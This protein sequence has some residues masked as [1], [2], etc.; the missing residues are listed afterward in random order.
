MN[1]N[2]IRNGVTFGVIGMESLSHG[3]YANV[4]ICHLTGLESEQHV[5]GDDV[6]EASQQSQNLFCQMSQRIL[7]GT[8]SLHVEASLSFYSKF[9]DL[10]V[11]SL[12]VLTVLEDFQLCLSL[13]TEKKVP[14]FCPRLNVSPGSNEPEQTCG[15][16]LSGAHLQPVFHNREVE[17]QDHPHPTP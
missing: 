4:I 9:F 12:V 16:L 13:E 11:S 5:G 7:K 8:F 17:A 15:H 6:A 3:V 1:L 14:N 2:F 10:K